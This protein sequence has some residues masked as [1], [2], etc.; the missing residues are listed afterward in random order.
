VDSQDGKISMGKYHGRNVIY[1]DLIRI[2]SCTEY[3]GLK[4]NRLKR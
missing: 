4:G 2:L 3:N 1:L